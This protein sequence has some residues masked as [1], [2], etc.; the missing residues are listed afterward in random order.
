LTTSAQS[1]R[2]NSSSATLLAKY[3]QQ[4]STVVPQLHQQSK[5]P[6][7]A[8]A[9]ATKTCCGIIY[10]QKRETC[11]MLA[12]DLKLLNIPCA[13]YHAS[14]SANERTEIQQKW[15]TN[16]VPIIIST[17]AFGMGID[18]CLQEQVRERASTRE[19]ERV[20]E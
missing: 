8:A 17:I 6:Q 1:K 12:T 18:V 14:L 19:R 3:F 2:S 16:E 4:A 10:C 7:P 20:R 5:P 9:M 13:A 11:D 15:E